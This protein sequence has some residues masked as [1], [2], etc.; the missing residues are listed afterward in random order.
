MG[1]FP[2]TSAE[3]NK[4][5]EQLDEPFLLNFSEPKW[6]KFF[7]SER[8]ISKQEMNGKNCTCW[9]PQL[10]IRKWRKSEKLTLAVL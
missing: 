1:K 3:T 8:S 10:K 2:E 9:A 4:L 6:L 7:K 5:F